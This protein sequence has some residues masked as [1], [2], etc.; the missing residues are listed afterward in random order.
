M[1]PGQLLIVCLFSILLQSSGLAQSDDLALKSQRAK[2]FMAEGKF[3]E[4]IALYR[5][6]NR[7]VPNNPGL[8]LNLGMALHMAGKERESTQQLEAAV[9]LDPALTPGWLF[10]GAARLQ[11]GKTSAG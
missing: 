8:V 11:L 2:K 7:A 1:T 9:K 6:L 3:V 4:S 10:L 5:E